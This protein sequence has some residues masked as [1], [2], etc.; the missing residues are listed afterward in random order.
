MPLRDSLTLNGAAIGSRVDNENA[1]ICVSGDFTTRNQ[2][3]SWTGISGAASSTL[4][5]IATRG[6]RTA[7]LGETEGEIVTTNAVDGQ[8]AAGTDVFFSVWG[9]ADYPNGDFNCST[10]IDI[11]DA[12]GV[13]KVLSGTGEA[14][15][16][17][18]GAEG[19]FTGDGVWGIEDAIGLLQVVAD[20]RP[21]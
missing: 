8:K 6:G 15:G 10:A 19:D 2:V 11:G 16:T 13:L 1:L 7:V 21:Q 3:A 20:V 5:A 12:V 9:A 18:L 4:T 14:P 17:C